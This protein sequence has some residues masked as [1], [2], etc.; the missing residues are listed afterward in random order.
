MFASAMIHYNNF[1][2]VHG[3]QQQCS[4]LYAGEKMRDNQYA[5]VDGLNIN[6]ASRS[7]LLDNLSKSSKISFKDIPKIFIY[8]RTPKKECIKRYKD[9]PRKNKALIWTKA[10]I[11]SAF[12]DAKIPKAKEFP[13]LE[14]LVVKNQKE[15]DLAKEYLKR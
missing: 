9:N 13:N 10:T 7:Y 5:I 6:K 8:F 15:I 4:I 11:K 1:S 2:I 14:V 12:W 3:I